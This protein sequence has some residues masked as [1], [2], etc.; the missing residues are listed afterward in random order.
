MNNAKK[1]IMRAVTRANEN[2]LTTIYL[3]IQSR[4]TDH[5]NKSDKKI[6]LYNRC[7]LDKAEASS[8]PGPEQGPW[9]A[10]NLTSKKVPFIARTPNAC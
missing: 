2:G 4:R 8:S 7:N 5:R 10:N 6:C 3:P 9:R 1:T